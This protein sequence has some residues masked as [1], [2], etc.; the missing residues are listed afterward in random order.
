MLLQP[1][2]NDRVRALVQDVVSVEVPSDHTDLIDS[3]LIDSLTLITMI[4]EIEQEF[5]V[6]LALDELDVEWFRSVDRIV[7]FLG[8][9]A[10]AA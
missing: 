6:E 8:R 10:V 2:L 5:G 1:S 7:Q 3:G 9:A 4:A